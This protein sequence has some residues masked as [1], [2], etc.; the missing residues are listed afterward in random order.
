MISHSPEGKLEARRYL[1]LV[2]TRTTLETDFLCIHDGLNIAPM[3]AGE[4][5]AFFSSKNITDKLG[6]WN[7]FP[8]FVAGSSSCDWQYRGQYDVVFGGFTAPGGL[9]GM[10]A[11][12]KDEVQKVL[13]GH[14]DSKGDWWKGL[15]QDWRINS[16]TVGGG[17]DELDRGNNE[18]GMRYVILKCRGFNEEFYNIW[19]RRRSVRKSGNSGVAEVAMS[20][21]G[22]RQ[23][24][25]EDSD[26]DVEILSGS[27]L[28]DMKGEDQEE[29]SGQNPA[30]IEVRRSGRK[31]GPNLSRY[32]PNP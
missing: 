2:E 10:N 1:R 22:R 11:S 15:R 12:R 30:A 7:N 4:C 20:S 14:R 16:T 25:E 6:K 17:L 29:P 5:G 23:D 13:Q 24:L 31:S 32:S 26:S 21:E 3:R 9:K 19:N 28:S 27:F 8:V 18:A